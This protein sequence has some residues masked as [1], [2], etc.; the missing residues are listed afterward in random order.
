[1][2]DSTILSTTSDLVNRQPNFFTSHEKL[3]T[4]T[5][6][7]SAPTSQQSNLKSSGLEGFRRQKQEAGVS[8]KI[9]SSWLQ[10]GDKKLRQPT[11]TA[12]N[13]GI[14]GVNQNN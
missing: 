13:S 2:A 5:R 12:G 8:E 3:A 9:P 4:A 14:I 10:V 1:M 7:S 11:T 6:G